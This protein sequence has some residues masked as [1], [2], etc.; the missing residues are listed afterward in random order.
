MSLPSVLV[1]D[2]DTGQSRSAVAAVQALATG[3][4]RPY[5]ATCARWSLAAAARGCAGR[6]AVPPVGD[7]GYAAAVRAEVESG[8]HV[9]VLPASDAALLALGEPGTGLIDKEELAR[10]AR[11]AGL[12]VP[13]QRA[14]ASAQALRAAADEL[15]YPV[16]V[17]P[18]LHTAASRLNATRVEGPEGLGRL[19]S[20]EGPVL[21]QPWLDA[22]MR[23]VAGL[24][25]DGRLVAAVH[26]RYLRTW[27]VDAGT[28]SA[29]V[30]VAPDRLLEERLVALLGGYDGIFQAQFVGDHLID[31]NPRVYGSLPL[32]V[33]AGANLPA[34]LCDLRAGRSP[35]P[36]RV[37]TGA[38]YRWPEGDLRHAIARRSPGVLRP[39]RAT[40][41]SVTS[42]RDPGPT[43]ARLAFAARAALGRS[44]PA[45]GR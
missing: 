15:D 8:G 5:V 17:K 32:A 30:T 28:A 40:A 6:V 36:V 43:L 23:A 12:A 21:V 31:L 7:G 27:P 16:A 22:P 45:P 33:A 11:A 25:W 13:A 26:Q 37:R 19:A 42:W 1:T 20:A 29:A 35:G 4:Y 38:H 41:H 14:F 39:R 10:R 24:V 34:L 18:A 44:A 3:G 2:G 9:C